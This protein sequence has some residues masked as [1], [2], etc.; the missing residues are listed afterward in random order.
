MSSNAARKKR[1]APTPS[2]FEALE[3]RLLLS[4]D[5]L[6][7]ALGADYLADKD[8]AE[9]DEPGGLAAL[10]ESLAPTDPGAGTLSALPELPPPVDLEALA[11]LSRAPADGG[12]RVLPFPAADD[13]QR[14]A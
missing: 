6:G 2:L 3:P 7:G 10:L 12:E 1:P 14:N 9:L 5:P 13:G 11:A 8:P 4:A